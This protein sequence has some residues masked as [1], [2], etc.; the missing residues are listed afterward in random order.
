MKAQLML[1]LIG[2]GR[3]ITP[4]LRAARPWLGISTRA[5]VAEVTLD[6]YGRIQRRFLEP[7]G[8]DYR[9]ANGKGTRGVRRHFIL[10]TGHIYEVNRLTGWNRQERVFMRVTPDGAIEEI[11]TKEGMLWLKNGI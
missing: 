4:A 6:H 5:W 7:G 9:E 3:N 8:L 11:N 2:W 10:E 1:E